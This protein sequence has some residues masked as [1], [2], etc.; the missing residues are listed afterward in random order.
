MENANTRCAGLV[1][2]ARLRRSC[3]VKPMKIV[4]Q[5]TTAACGN[6]HD[7]NRRVEWIKVTRSNQQSDER[8]EDSKKHYA[9]LH[10]RDEIAKARR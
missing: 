10:Q 9:R 2:V 5:T 6:S 1:S 8:G 3:T 7:R 4:P